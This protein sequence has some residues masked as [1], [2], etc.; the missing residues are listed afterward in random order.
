MQ[1]RGPRVFEMHAFGEAALP[2]IH[3]Q[4]IAALLEPMTAVKRA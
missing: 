2:Q 4:P 1:A 3:P